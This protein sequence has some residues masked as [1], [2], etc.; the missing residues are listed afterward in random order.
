M[1]GSIFA[2]L[3]KPEA[4]AG[5]SGSVEDMTDEELFSTFLDLLERAGGAEAL[6]TTLRELGEERLAESVLVCATCTTA[7]EFIAVE[8]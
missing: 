2:P 7:S 1:N 4:R 3:H 5:L 6:A 8:A